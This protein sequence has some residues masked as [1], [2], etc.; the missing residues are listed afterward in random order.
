MWRFVLLSLQLR[1]VR[2]PLVK[3]SVAESASIERAQILTEAARSSHYSQAEVSSLHFEGSVPDAAAL[4]ARWSSLLQEAHE[5]VRALPTD[6]VARCVLGPK[7]VHH[8]EARRCQEHAGKA[9]RRRRSLALR[10]GGPTQ[11]IFG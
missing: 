5:V 7:Q 2:A 8:D 3:S 11:R 1:Q 6:E 4:S 10:Q 9:G